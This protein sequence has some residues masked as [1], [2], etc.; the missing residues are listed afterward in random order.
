MTPKKTFVGH[1]VGAT[2][3]NSCNIS[4]KIVSEVKWDLYKEITCMIFMVFGLKVGGI[5]SNMCYCFVWLQSYIVVLHYYIVVF[6]KRHIY[7][8]ILSYRS[9]MFLQFLSL[10]S[11]ICVNLCKLQSC[12]RSQ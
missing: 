12:L 7:D 2:M 6:V 8:Y 10:E 3:M 11:I 9:E 4:K 1:G 5:K